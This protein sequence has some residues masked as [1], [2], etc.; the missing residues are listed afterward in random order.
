MY[1]VYM[2]IGYVICCLLI[3]YIYNYIRQIYI[4]MCVC[5]CLSLELEASIGNIKPT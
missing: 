3:Y 5:L 2:Y 4:Y 1:K